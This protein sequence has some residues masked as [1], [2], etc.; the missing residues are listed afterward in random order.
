M[1][2]AVLTVDDVKIRRWHWWSNWI[3][4]AVF[5]LAHHKQVI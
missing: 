1:K 4:V 2:V 5:D 3:D